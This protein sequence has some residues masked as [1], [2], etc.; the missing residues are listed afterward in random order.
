LPISSLT[1]SEPQQEEHL[2]LESSMMH[3]HLSGKE[4]Q[5]AFI[6]AIHPRTLSVAQPLALG[7]IA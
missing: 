4:L 1:Q 6:P 3:L 5:F 7:Q 2:Q